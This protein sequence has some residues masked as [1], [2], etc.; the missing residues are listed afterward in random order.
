MLERRSALGGRQSP[1]TATALRD[2]E[3]RGFT[4][5]QV[6][7]FDAGF[8]KPAHKAVRQAAAKVGIAVAS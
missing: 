7:G 2:R 3:A 5:T 6:A 1:M 8:E 4:L